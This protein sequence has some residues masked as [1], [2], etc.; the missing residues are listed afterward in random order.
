M[1]IG[2]PQKGG[3]K[4]PDFWRLCF[5][6]QLVEKTAALPET[7]RRADRESGENPWLLGDFEPAFAVAPRLL[8]VGQ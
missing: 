4:E 3:Q 2:L 8:N 1:G 6:C 5:S 7:A